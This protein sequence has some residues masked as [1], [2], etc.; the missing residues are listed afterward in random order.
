[1]AKLRLS[2]FSARS[3][4]STVKRKAK[5]RTPARRISRIR[6]LQTIADVETDSKL[7]PLGTLPVDMSNFTKTEA[8]R[9][10]T[11]GMQALKRIGKPEEGADVVAFMAS[12]GARWI[13]GARLRRGPIELCVR[14]GPMRCMGPMRPELRGARM[15]SMPPS[16]TLSTVWLLCCF[17]A[18]PK[19][20]REPRPAFAG[21]GSLTLAMSYSRTT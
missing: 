14:M 11:F 10:V 5:K 17:D 13:T 7:D 6:F 15:N 3:S 2:I 8:G 20:R 16:Q 21:R 1:M 4:G 18:H 9:E 19:K 12:D